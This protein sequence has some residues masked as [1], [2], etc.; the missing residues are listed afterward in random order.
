M[1]S[2]V[3]STMRIP[4]SSLQLPSSCL[5]RHQC[6]R[7]PHVSVYNGYTWPLSTGMSSSMTDDVAHDITDVTDA[8]KKTATHITRRFNRMLVKSSESELD[9]SHLIGAASPSCH[10][11]R[12]WLRGRAHL[13][14]IH[15]PSFYDFLCLCGRALS[16]G[17]SSWSWSRTKRTRADDG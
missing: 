4:E 13:R 11:S 12:P 9:V 5:M 8:G 16:S 6:E 17:N 2:L 15:F 1:G 10:R 14:C 3:P 7:Q